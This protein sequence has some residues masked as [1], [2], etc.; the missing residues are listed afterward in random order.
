MPRYN[1]A[2]IEPK[3][4]AFWDKN[5]TFAAPRMPKPGSKKLYALDMFPYPS[6]D[7]LHVG[8]PEG[9][10]ATDIVCRAARMQGKSVMHPMGFDAF[11]LPAE[12]HAIKT[13]EHPRSRTEKNID[14]FR[15]QLKSLG[16]SYDW[17][18]EL[19]TTD[20][21][22]VRWTQWIFLQI[23]DTWFDE[24]QQRGRPIS[25]LPIPDDVRSQGDDAVRTYQD[26]HRLAYQNEAPV[27]WCLALGTVLANEEVVNGK[28][29]VGGHP[30]VRMPLRQWMLRITAYADRLEKDLEGLDWSEGIKSLQRNWIGRSTGA[31]VDFMI[32]Q[33]GVGFDDFEDIVEWHSFSQQCGFSSEP[34]DGELRVYTTRPDTLFGATY[35][36]VAPE[37]RLVNELAIYPYSKD[38]KSYCEGAARKSDLE[39]TELSKTKSGVFTGSYAVNPVN[40]ESIPIWVADYVLGSY[41]TGAIM[42][43]PAHDDR[44]FEFAKQFKLPIKAVV[45]PGD[46]IPPAERNEVLAGERC[47]VGE[48]MAIN[49]GKYNGLRTPEF[50]ARISNDLAAQGLGRKAVNYKLRDWLFSR[51]RFWGEPFPILHEV[52]SNGKPTGRVRA[53]DEKD[54]PVDLPHLDDF[55]PHGRPE[56]PLDK[57]PADWLYQTID[58]K[59]YKRETNTMPQW[60]GSC[61]Y[62]LRFLDPKNNHALIDPAIEKAWMPVDLYIGGAEHAVLHLLYARFWHKV[63]YDR[64]VVSMPEPFQKLINQGMILGENNEKMSKSRGNVINPDKIVTEYGAD[65]LRLYEMF[66]GPL[67]AAKPWNMQGVNGVFGFLNR[68]WRLIMD[69]RAETMQLNPAVVDR[70][71][72]AD[73]NRIL[74]QTIQAV[75]S[76][77]GNLAFNT[78]ISRMME[79]TNYFTSASE[80]PREALEK[81]VLLL[82]PF[83]PHIAEEL[84]QAL[85]HKQSLAYEPWPEFD[86]ALAK[87]DTVE[88]PVQVNGKLRSK[89]T[90][91]TDADK[92]QLESAA[93]ADEKVCELLNG[94]Q[95]VKVIVVPGRLVNFVIK[96]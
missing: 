11:G 70:A 34:S 79:F 61:W 66:M 84:W 96:G 25:E 46:A 72:N 52:D 10:T 42:A 63:L 51:Q 73:E 22:Y 44:D 50:K 89:I 32:R 27:N 8:H 47:F 88:V 54:L 24:E 6:G 39:R 62:Y 40:D 30:V 29:E 53:V 16:F 94:K 86:P 68:V 7:G 43:V 87:E 18:R 17:S 2:T 59:R 12:E 93:R 45:D 48:G 41:G 37:H 91:A 92:T 71:P 77:I 75:T 95:L 56:P 49:S 64:G 20:V 81:L 76:D 4:Q 55:K 58:G 1:H 21:E 14:T 5:Q 31:N 85:G 65:S 28:S 19:A 35:I 26:E 38:V 13:G 23:Y 74:H 78:A 9:Y 36:V 3:W 82:S 90:V 33:P 57:A 67:E 80:R 60:A 83:A 15:R 69:E